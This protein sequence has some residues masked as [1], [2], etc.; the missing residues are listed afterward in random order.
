MNH[1]DLLGLFKS[2]HQKCSVKEVVPKRLANF[3]GK[4]LCRSLFLIKLQTQSSNFIKKR[5]QDWCFSVKFATFLRTSILEN[6]C[7]RLLLFVSSQNTIAYSSGK[8]GLDETLTECKASII[9]KHNNFIPS[10]AVISFKYKLKNVPVTFRLI[11]LLNFLTLRAF[12]IF[13]FTP[14]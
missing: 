11:F 7:E 3:T 2:S 9:F 13:C 12:E 8:F 1:R 14:G 6:I 5:L 4:P 10:N